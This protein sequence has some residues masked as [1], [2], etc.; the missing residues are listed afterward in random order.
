MKRTA[1]FG[2]TTW[3]LV[4]LGV[5]AASLPA[6]AAMVEATGGFDLQ[7][8]GSVWTSSSV[9]GYVNG[10][11][12]SGYAGIAKFT[13]TR[14]ANDTAPDILLPNSPEGYFIGI[15]LEFNEGLQSNTKLWDLKSLSEGPI[16]ANDNPGV[17]MGARAADLAR[18]LN[19]VYANWGSTPADRTFTTA[20]Q[21]AVWEIANEDLDSAYNLTAN[22][23]RIYFTSAPTAARTLAQGWLNKIGNEFNDATQYYRALTRDGTQDFVVRVVPIP[24]AAWLLG[25]GLLGL[26]AVGR[27]KKISA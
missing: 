18:L 20:L 16:D 22:T 26:I 14:S 12:A 7:N 13:R 24:A 15:C 25:S 2:V 11:R 23:G 21:L 1:G 5:L 10:V 27:R 17:P 9:V 19:G 8:T 3:S 4:A 6:S